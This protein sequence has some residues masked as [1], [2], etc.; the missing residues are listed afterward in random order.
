[1]NFSKSLYTYIIAA[2]IS[3]TSFFSAKG[4]TIDITPG[5]L[6]ESIKDAEISENLT[7][8]GNGDIRDLVILRNLPPT[9]KSLDLT[10]LKIQSFESRT[11][12]YMG[13]TLF[14][15]TRL[16]AYIF[17]RSEC[18]NI[19]LPD[20][21][22]IIEEG[23][24]ASSD[25]TSVK[26][27]EGI[28]E[29]G[30]YAFYGCQNLTSVTLPSSLKIIG[31]GAFEKCPKLK[32]INIESTKVVALPEKCF[33]GDSSLETLNLSKIETIGTEALAATSIVTLF[34]PDVEDFAP[35]ALAGM[36]KLCELTLNSKATFN[37]GTLMNNRNLI[38]LEGIPQNIPP[39]F[40]ANCVSYSAND[41]LSDADSVGDFAF[42]N[43]APTEIILGNRITSIGR[44]ILKGSPNLN[45]IDATILGTNIPETDNNAFE[46]IDTWNIRLKVMDHAE[47][48][49]KSHPVWG[50]FNV[51]SDF[52]SDMNMAQEIKNSI[53]V[54]LNDNKIEISAPQP[55]NY[56][57]IFDS[58]GKLLKSGASREN[59]ATISLEALPS[60]VLIVNVVAGENSKTVKIIL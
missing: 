23:A 55:I 32:D 47:E 31:K 26:L 20:G 60:G 24:F 11:P 33:A 16:P 8:A 46:G 17:F 29:I 28:T 50:N 56:F 18:R 48:T 5:S 59:S 36:E 45:H 43:S 7:V 37:I 10:K 54:F 2:T 1:M 3:A 58:E 22:T 49:W 27:P 57:A 39:L 51:Y 13:K 12:V 4:E 34:L 52:T 21:L 14:N 6:S 30:N 25:L 40:A 38:Q 44:G 41:A 15:D 42:S 35:F 9:V 19:D 53:T